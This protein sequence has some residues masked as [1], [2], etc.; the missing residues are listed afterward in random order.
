MQFV[1]GAGRC[2]RYVVTGCPS[3]AQTELVS[4]ARARR[5]NAID[6]DRRADARGR[7]SASTEPW[8]GSM[9]EGWTRWVLE[10]YGF[11]FVTLRPADFRA[12]LARQGR[13]RHPGRR[14]AVPV[15]GAAAGGRARRPRRRRAPC[16]PS[17]PTSSAPRICARFEQFVRGGGTLVCLEQRQHLRDPA[18]QAAGAK[19]RRRPAARG[20][21]PARIDRRGR[22]SIPS[23]PVMAGMPAQAAVFVDGSPVFETLD[24]FTGRVLAR[25]GRPDRRCCPG[26]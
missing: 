5:P 14:C 21:L 16:G 20:V 26:I 3:A 2:V 23:H 25:I 17:T 9:D 12:P 11:E 8:G 22:R 19:R 10:Q 7:A 1:A 6:A 24:G 15:E 18:V 4:V 13:R